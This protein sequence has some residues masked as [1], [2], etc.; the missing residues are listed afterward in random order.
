MDE[1]ERRKDLRDKAARAWADAGQTRNHR[2][3]RESLDAHSAFQEALRS[4]ADSVLK[5]AWKS[6]LERPVRPPDRFADL[7]DDDDEPSD[8]EIAQAFEAS[9]ETIREKRRRA[10]EKFRRAAEGMGGKATGDGGYNF[11][12]V[13]EFGR[14]Q[15]R[16]GAPRSTSKN[17]NPDFPHRWG[18]YFTK[19]GDTFVS[20]IPEKYLERLTKRAPRISDKAWAKFLAFNGAPVD[21]T[22]EAVTS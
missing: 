18:Q 21:A 7:I 3:A 8:A 4:V 13:H 2:S 15:G 10:H 9:R 22:W 11:S 20:T 14:Q 5:S 19:V 1:E 17:R 6:I 12:F 16:Q